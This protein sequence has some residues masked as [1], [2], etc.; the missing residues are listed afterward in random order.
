MK[1]NVSVFAKLG[2]LPFII[3]VAVALY[4]APAMAQIEINDI[5]ELQLIGN[6]PG[7]PLDGDYVLGNDIDASAT[8]SWNGDAGFATATGC[9][10]PR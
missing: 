2:V 8:T 1:A 7:Y 10:P 9:R 6:D 4:A 5:D 3:M